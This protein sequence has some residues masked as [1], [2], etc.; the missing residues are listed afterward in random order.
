MKDGAIMWAY[1]LTQAEAEFTEAAIRTLGSTRWPSALLR[2]LEKQG[3]DLLAQHA[4]P[5]RSQGGTRS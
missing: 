1:T 3:W 5:V 2:H 4:A